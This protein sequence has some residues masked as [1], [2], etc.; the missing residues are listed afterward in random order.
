[1]PA[2]DIAQYADHLNTY[3]ADL[4]PVGL[5]YLFGS[6]ARGKAGPLSDVDIAV[7]LED[8]PD[9]DTCF[10][11][12]LEIIG[13]MMRILQTNDVDV[14]ILNQAPLTFQYQVVRDGVLIFCRDRRLAVECRCR[15]LNLYFDFEPLLERHKQ[16]FFEKVRKGKLL[17]GHNPYRGTFGTDS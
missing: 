17:S 3:F 15:A 2:L 6:P 7:L 8:M 12:R 11:L 10:D 16:T 14:V 9:A 5:V 13:G 1:M 4:P